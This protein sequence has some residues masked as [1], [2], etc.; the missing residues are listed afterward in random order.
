MP[1][2]LLGNPNRIPGKLGRLPAPPLPHQLRMMSQY[3]GVALPKA[4]QA[5]DYYSKIPVWPVNGNNEYGCCA[6]A[7]A[8]HMHECW[9]AIIGREL[10]W[11]GKEKTVA[12][13]F[14]LTG[15]I[16]SGLIEANVLRHWRRFGLAGHK[17]DAYVP[18]D[19]KDPEGIKQGT[20]LFGGL[21]VGISVP[22]AAN[23]QFTAGEPWTVIRRDRITGGHA[24]PL[25][26]YDDDFLYCVTWGA[27]QRMD[28][29]F[30]DR[31]GEE[32]WAVL[33]SEF[34]EHGK[35]PASY[36]LAALRA[37]LDEISRA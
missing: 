5:V 4:P 24:V 7:T 21:Y 8:S 9:S 18:V 25:V 34:V 12:E 20:W 13:Y 17:I 32:A 26:G 3:A 29:D 19:P 35:G 2:F 14:N 1:D 16:D 36:D 22:S 23:A 30:W 10:T 15:G 27:I 37:N 33:P 11:F 6:I 31:H 28:W